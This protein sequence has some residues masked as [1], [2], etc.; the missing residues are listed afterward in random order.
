[1][2]QCTPMGCSCPEP[3]SPMGH[4]HSSG[5]LQMFGHTHFPLKKKKKKRTVGKRVVLLH[6]LGHKTTIGNPIQSSDN[7]KAHI[8]TAPRTQPSPP[9]RLQG[10]SPCFINR[11]LGENR[12]KK[13]FFKIILYHYRTDFS[14]NKND[15]HHLD[16]HWVTLEVVQYNQ[17]Y[18]SLL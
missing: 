6:Q 9:Q 17:L 15:F 2:K 13:I 14:K 18:R 11:V 12:R 10:C 8:Q 5:L 4:P 16:F 7:V 1:M 3:F